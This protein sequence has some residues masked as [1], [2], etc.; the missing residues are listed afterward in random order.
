MEEDDSD[1][2]DSGEVTGYTDHNKDWLKPAKSGEAD[3]GD[4]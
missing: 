1:V 4:T 3:V 2:S